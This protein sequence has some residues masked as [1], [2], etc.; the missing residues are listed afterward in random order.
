ML[1]L[2]E[3]V[4]R[5][6]A[7]R[8]PADRLEEVLHRDVLAAEGSG[9]DGTAVDEDGRHVE[10]H[11]R[12]HHAGQRLVAAGE[13]DQRVVA[14]AAHGQLD[15]VGD[16]VARHQRGL[17]PLVAHGDAVGDGD[18]GELARRAAGL[19][20]APLDR[21]CLTRERDVA[22]CGLVPAGGDA[23]QGL[24]DLRLVEPHRVVV[25]AV[26]RATRPLGH[27]PRWQPRLVPT[28]RSVLV[29]HDPVL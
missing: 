6:V 18:G 20:H 19:V 29:R 5:H 11:H 12:H 26:R 14:V 1:Q 15:G 21:L 4:V 9:Q 2:V 16:G 7:D 24:V 22:G 23:D 8:M 17:H 10:A 3:V 28:R 13:P 25:R 27:V